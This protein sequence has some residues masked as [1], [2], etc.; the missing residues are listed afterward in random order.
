MQLS[1]KET[2]IR[3]IE[4]IRKELTE[5]DSPLGIELPEGL[6]Q[7]STLVIELL[8][9]YEPV[10]FVD[11]CYGACDVK[12]NRAKELGCKTLLHFGH[13][14]MKGAR[15]ARIKTLFIPLEYDLGNEQFEFITC[16]IKR[17]GLK[18]IN[19]VTTAQ[20][21]SSIE[22]VKRLLERDGIEVIPSRK[23]KRLQ[24]HQV[25]GC[26]ESNIT[27]KSSP[28]V[29]IGDGYFHADN[30]SYIHKHQDIYVINPLA[31]ATEKRSLN[32]LFLRQR[33]AAIAKA[34]ECKSFGI[35]VSTKAGQNRIRLA[36][37]IKHKLE[38]IG[39]SAYIFAS[40]YINENYLLGV[41]VE[42]YINTACPRIA[43]EDFTSFKKPILSAT[44][45]EQLIDI[46][47]KI[48]ID[49]IR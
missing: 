4:T 11:P 10:L 24:E 49:Q 22:R 25:L 12:A 1:L 14:E 30:I 45:V 13:K 39:K 42:C 2:L 48:K 6:K 23:T 35:L 18:R 7:F 32:E 38:G 37:S 27:D 9:D 31:R 41:A 5:K 20:Y 3:E 26:D 34:M 40:D 21:L 29:F 46:K 47:K 28:I 19:L 17:L 33:Y 15:K 8:K 16:E 36:R 43:Y 44:E